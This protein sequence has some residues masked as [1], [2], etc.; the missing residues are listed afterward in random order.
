MR[1]LYNCAKDYICDTHPNGAS[2][3]ASVQQRIEFVLSHPNSWQ[4][5]EQAQMRTAAIRARLIPHTNEGHARIHFVTEGEAS[6]LYCIQRDLAMEAVKVGLCLC[7]SYSSIIL[8]S[9]QDGQG[10]LIV[11]AGGGTIDLSAYAAS[12][13][14]YSFQEIAATQCVL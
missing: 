9:S 8:S 7:C 14:G 11:D 12:N 6:L 3:W 1:Y 2:L 10:V 13:S 5:A 4:G